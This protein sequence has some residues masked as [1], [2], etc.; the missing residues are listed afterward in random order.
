MAVKELIEPLITIVPLIQMIA[1][2]CYF[3]RQSIF[4][5][6]RLIRYEK[7]RDTPRKKL[8]ATPKWD[9]PERGSSLFGPS[10]VIEY[11][12]KTEKRLR[13][14]S[15]YVAVIEYHFL[16]KKIYARSILTINKVR[17]RTVIFCV[18]LKDSKNLKYIKPFCVLSQLVTTIL[19][20]TAFYQS[21]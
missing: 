8:N 2:A 3:F 15:V 10:L 13:T 18:I 7:K 14:K 16:K 6:R 9:Q 12:S 4:V 1:K 5:S 17:R 21:F 19:I 11:Q 20:R